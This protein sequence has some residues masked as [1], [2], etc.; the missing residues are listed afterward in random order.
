MEALAAL[1]PSSTEVRDGDGGQRLTP[2]RRAA[3]VLLMSEA[4]AKSEGYQPLA[5]VRSWAVAAVDPGGQLLMGPALAIRRPSSAPLSSSR[6]W[7]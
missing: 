6:T 5:Y 7:T 2:D 4:K 3:A 1:P